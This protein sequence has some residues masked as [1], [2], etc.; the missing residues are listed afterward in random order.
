MD[1]ICCAILDFDAHLPPKEFSCLCYAVYFV[2]ATFPNTPDL[3]VICPD[4]KCQTGNR[5]PSAVLRCIERAVNKIFELGDK[6]ILASYQK[7]WAFETPAPNEFV[8]TIAFHL[9]AD[10]PTPETPS[11]SHLT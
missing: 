11:T 5:S 10:A 7:S 3:K 9:R 8:R 2:R 4:I 1:R 6:E